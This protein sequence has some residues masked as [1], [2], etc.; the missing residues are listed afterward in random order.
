MGD[1]EE[2]PTDNQ[3]PDT[4]RE[5][6]LKIT[7]SLHPKPP[8]PLKSLSAKVPALADV[9]P[10]LSRVSSVEDLKEPPRPKN[11]RKNTRRRNRAR[12]RRKQSRKQ[13]TCPAQRTRKSRK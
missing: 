13:R 12:K 10:A 7:N 11:R 9:S 2:E 5:E 4:K 3:S 6:V 8:T 1:D